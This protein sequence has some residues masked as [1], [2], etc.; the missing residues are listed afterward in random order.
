MSEVKKFVLSAFVVFLLAA[1]NTNELEFDNIQIQ[2]ITGV[3]ALPLGEISYT[4]RQ[5]IEEE[6]DGELELE[7]DSTSLLTF[8][9]RDTISYAIDNEFVNITDISQ[10]GIVTVP[11]E[12][13]PGTA[14]PLS[15]SFTLTYDAQGNEELD[16]VFY[17]SGT[18]S[19]VTTSTA[20]G[21][22][23]YSYEIVNTRSVATDASLTL[24]G[25]LN[26]AGTDTQTSSLVG[27]KTTLN[28]NNE[29]T[30]NFTGTINLG[31]AET[32]TGNEELRFDVTY[33]NQTFSIVY[34]K[35]GQDTVQFGNQTLDISFFNDLG[36]EGLIF[37]N[38]IMKFDFQ[39]EFGI[40]ISVDFSGIN[41]SDGGGG[42]QT[43][44]GGS[45][46]REPLPEIASPDAD[47]P[48]T[49]AES[50][51]EINRGNSS[52]VSL[53]ATSPSELMFDVKGISNMQNPNQINFVQPGNSIEAAI[54]IE[55]PLEIQLQ[56]LQ[57]TLYYSLG[58]GL[59]T[60]N[61]D[62]AFVRI[63]TENELPFSGILEMEIQDIDSN[64]LY[65]SDETV[66]LNSPFINI[67]GFVTDANGVANDLYLSQAGVDALAVGA[68]LVLKVTLNT[69]TSLTSRNIYVK[70]LAD[71]ELLIRVGV[72]GKVNIDL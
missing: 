10:S 58:D 46:T 47:S 71:Y 31:V 66:V 7:E 22:L 30:I 6:Q 43:F 42:T 34:G 14:V 72:G 41:G 4:M 56:N 59:D 55:I 5:L 68:Y 39:N 36:E 60:E 54:E 29:F 25:N 69:P 1:C 12:L 17:N 23:S 8:I 3:Y 2:P 37:G 33:A 70:V 27:Y 9:Y 18:V 61:V 28:N 15:Q 57:K 19:I 63:Y 50:T 32:L 26:G 40:P 64:T 21:A 11:Q 13:T 52:I 48:G 62:S 35:F 38:P 49:I 65:T 53:F 16:S 44:L 67:N 45:I 20:P 24:N 51:I